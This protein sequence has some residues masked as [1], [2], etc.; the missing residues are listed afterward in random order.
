MIAPTHYTGHSSAKPRSPAMTTRRIPRSAAPG[1]A[2]RSPAKSPRPSS[3]PTAA[4]PKTT[5]CC[6]KTASASKA[7]SFSCAIPIPTAIADSKRSPRS[8]KA[9]PRCSSTAIPPKTATRKVRSIP[10]APGARNIKFSAAP[11]PTTSW[12]PAIRKLP[13]GPPSPAQNAFRSSRRSPRR[14]SWRCRSPGTTPSRCSKIMDGPVA[15]ERLARRLAVSPI[16]SAA[17]A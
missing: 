12:S 9:P 6:A 1:S 3:T 17:S 2:C 10:T 7:K 13:D 15:P 8:A 5:I 4:I 16:T 11:S 14:K